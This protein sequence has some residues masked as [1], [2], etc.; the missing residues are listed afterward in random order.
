MSCILAVDIGTT[1][2]KGLVVQSDGEVLSSS[3]RA[4]ITSYPQPGYA[5]Q[6]ADELWNAVKQV[7]IESGE[8]YRDQISGISF[9]CA[10]HSL[11]VVDEKGNALS[12]VII[13]ADTRSAALAKAL[14]TSDEGKRMYITTGTP[15]H[16]SSPLCKLAWMKREQPGLFQSAFKLVSIKEYIWF[17]LVG[18]WEIDYSLASATGLFDIHQ[19]QWMPEALAFAGIDESKLSKC[20]SPY[21]TFT[22][23]EKSL[24]S[25]LTINASVNLIIGGSDGCLANLG[26][27]VMSADELSVTIGTSGAVRTTSRTCKEDQQQRVFNYRLDEDHFIVGGATNNGSVLLSWFSENILKEQ[28]DAPL[29]VDRAMEI[30]PGS[31]GLIF[32]PYVMGERAPFYNPDACALFFGLAQHHTH[33]HMMRALLE[34]ICFELRSIVEAVE[35]STGKA[36]RVI[37]SGGF[38][39]S[40]GW[41]QLLADILNKEV[42]I[43]DSN[44]AS[45]LGAAKIGFRAL[46]MRYDFNDAQRERSFFPTEGNTARYNPYYVLFGELTDVL[47]DKM[48]R[49]T[50]LQ[51]G[52]LPK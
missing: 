50:A 13:W 15:I 21:H 20:V 40:A 18:K 35:A 16:P 36:S 26:S 41:V 34:G 52:L 9:S 11:L 1:S 30:A 42:S 28:P 48:D 51:S 17:K 14:R 46:K 5:E 49:I 45:A 10:M 32:L 33:A 44:N 31:E 43:T 23:I 2:T 7:I 22:G 6:S 3:H 24:A 39:G 19:L 8:R 12:P 38:T 25:E 4:Y 37:A 29:F 27:G 47:Q